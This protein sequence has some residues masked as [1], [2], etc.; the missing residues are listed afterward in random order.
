MTLIA[1]TLLAVFAF[2]VWLVR[3]RHQFLGSGVVFFRLF[4]ISMWMLLPTESGESGAYAVADGDFRTATPNE[5]GSV[6]RTAA[7]APESEQPLHAARGR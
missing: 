1:L 7:T 2:G 4:L 5:S 6:N 3:L